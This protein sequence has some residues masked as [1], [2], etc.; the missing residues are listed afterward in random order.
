[1]AGIVAVLLLWCIAAGATAAPSPAAEATVPRHP[2]ETRALTAPADVLAGLPALRAAAQARGDARELSLLALAES[3]ACRMLSRLPCQSEAAA[4]ARRIAQQAGAPD[5]EVRGYVLEASAAI[6]R[7]DFTLAEQLLLEAEAVLRRH[8]HPLLMGDVMLAYSSISFVLGNPAR[9]EEYARRGLESLSAAPAHTIRVR[10]L[11]N[12]ARALAPQGRYDEAMAALAQGLDL[13]PSDEDPR[14]QA[15]LHTEAARLA[16]H[17]GDLA[18]QREH[19]EA[20]LAIGEQLGSAPVRGM[21]RELLADAAQ[22]GGDAGLA[23]TLFAATLDD[24]ARAQQPRDER[25]VLRRLLALELDRDDAEAAEPHVRRLIELGTRLEAQDQAAIAANFD[26]R[27]EQAEQAY[28]M[29]LLQQSMASAARQQALLRWLIAAGAALSL[30]LAWAVIAQRRGSAR[31]AQALAH[32]RDNEARYQALTD[33][34]PAAIVELDRELRFRRANAW[35]AGKVGLPAAAMIGRSVRELSGAGLYAQWQPHLEAALAG[36]VARCRVQA[37]RNGAPQYLESTFLP[38]RAPDG[39]VDGIYALT[40]DVT[41][42]QQAQDALERLAR[43]DSL[44]GVANRRHFEE[45]LASVLAHARRMHRG[46]AVLALDLDRFKAINDSLGHAG[47]DAVLREFVARVTAC[48]RKDDF[49]A[50]VGGDEFVLIVEE[51]P[52]MAGEIIARKLLGVMQP[53]MTVLGRDL[54]VT[55]SIGVALGDGRHTGEQMLTAA[56]EALYA[57][58]AEGRATFIVRHAGHEPAPLRS[59]E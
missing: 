47:G 38:R 28:E 54:P 36:E 2:E 18:A 8:P 52:A 43:I 25:R 53:P 24:F 6:A 59:P 32:A 22:A 17:R 9:S 7:Q 29:Q 5:L 14:L 42:L 55:V 11:R 10:L 23:E 12:L 20:A 13:V 1:M 57:A 44:T 37:A 39:S 27:L 4:Q 30:V 34:M 35:L 33:H 16:Q 50:R 41:E 49:L 51:P 31:L 26:V 48:V 46:V 40:F 45:R 19:A 21:G 58:K 56:D 15:E 3:N